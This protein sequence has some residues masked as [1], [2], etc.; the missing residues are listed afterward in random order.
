M[1]AL[2]LTRADHDRLVALAAAGLPLEVCGLLAGRDGRVVQIYPVANQLAS[3]HAF[4]LAPGPFVAAIFDLEARGLELLAIY[5]SHPD[6]PS[7]PSVTDVARAAYPEALQ[8]I[9][10][11]ADR[12]RPSVAAF[13]V[14]DG[15]VEPVALEMV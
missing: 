10:S 4:E 9:I 7:A 11:L 14:A 15:R 3:R 2:R 12:A 13:R 6:G 5:H 1:N 8:V